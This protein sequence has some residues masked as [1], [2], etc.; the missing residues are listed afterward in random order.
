MSGNIGVGFPMLLLW[1][2]LKRFE[3]LRLSC[4]H[5]NGLTQEKGATLSLICIKTT[6]LH[7]VNT[8]LPFVSIEHY[9]I[10]VICHDT[11]NELLQVE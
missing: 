9:P 5:N 4:I 11:I 2:K 7:L 10:D 3:P 6:I 8:Y 1:T